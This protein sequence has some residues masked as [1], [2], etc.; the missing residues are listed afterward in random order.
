MLGDWARGL[1]G[2]QPPV[3]DNCHDMMHG[4]QRVRGLFKA[5]GQFE[6]FLGGVDQMQSISKMWQWDYLKRK[7]VTYFEAVCS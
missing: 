1:S 4:P 6:C 7:L 2:H 5:Q 3:S